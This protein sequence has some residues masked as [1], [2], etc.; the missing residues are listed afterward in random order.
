MKKI[1]FSLGFILISYLVLMVQ[2]IYSNSLT[3]FNVKSNLIILL[4]AFLL[5]YTNRK[6][7]IK[8][9]L[10]IGTIFDLT[11]SQILVITPITLLISIIVMSKINKIFN[12]KGIYK[13]II[14]IFVLTMIFELLFYICKM[15]FQN[16]EWK[17][18]VLR[19]IF[20]ESIFNVMIGIIVYPI[21]SRIGN[22]VYEYYQKNNILTRYF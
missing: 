9:S 16:F 4:V 5:V 8:I 1:L 13:Y 21:L 22:R 2:W 12:K 14:N 18:T 6:E 7:A 20:I 10:I 3:I 17:E 19:I 15:G 11:V